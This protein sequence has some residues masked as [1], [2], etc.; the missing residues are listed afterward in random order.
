MRIAGVALIMAT[1]LPAVAQDNQSATTAV[2]D[3]DRNLTFM[4]SKGWEWELNAGL[5]IGGATPLG[6]PREVRKV[7]TYNLN[8]TEA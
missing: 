8:S 5:N 7:R 4:T 3:R 6:M 1:T 2:P